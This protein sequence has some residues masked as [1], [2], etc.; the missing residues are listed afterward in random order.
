V[1]TLGQT[2]TA[3]AHSSVAH[4]QGNTHSQHATLRGAAFL[5]WDGVRH[6]SPPSWPTIFLTPRPHD[7]SQIHGD[8][9]NVQGFDVL[10]PPGLLRQEHPLTDRAKATIQKARNAAMDIIAGEDDRLLVIVGPC[11]IHDA[12]QG[13]T[14][15]EIQSLVRSRTC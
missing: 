1:K 15:G 10:I 11:S 6:Q 13:L 14:V 9:L 12:E 7:A 4:H 2:T 5:A 3:A 8:D